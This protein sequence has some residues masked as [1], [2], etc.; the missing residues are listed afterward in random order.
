MG[1]GWGDGG[2]GSDGGRR[3]VQKA[4]RGFMEGGEGEGVREEG[5]G[6]GVWEVVVGGGLEGGLG[7]GCLGKEWGDGVWEVIVGKGRFRRGRR[8]FQ[9]G[10]GGR[11][12]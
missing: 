3:R 10:V 2:L 11:G 6:E 1:K 5:W 4:G 7:E 8:E 12:G 9:K